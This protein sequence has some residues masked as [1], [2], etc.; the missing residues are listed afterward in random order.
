M[1]MV[2]VITPILEVYSDKVRR[3]IET[4]DNV[5]TVKDIVAV[6]PTDVA[7]D[8]IDPD[9]ISAIGAKQLED[10]PLGSLVLFRHTHLLEVCPNEGNQPAK[11]LSS[12]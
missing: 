5:I 12:S 10:T 4:S 1:P 8:L 11:T 9:D 2:F 7:N 6:L 3:V